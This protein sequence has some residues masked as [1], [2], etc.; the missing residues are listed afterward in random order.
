[1]AFTKEQCEKL[2][3]TFKEGMTDDEVFALVDAKHQESLKVKAS[4]DKASSELATLKKEK[5][6]NLSEEEK[7]KA[8]IA[9]LEEQLAKNQKEATIRDVKDQYVGLGY[10]PELAG[11]I[12]NASIEG[13]H[14]EVAKLQKEFMDAHDAKLKEDFMKSNPKPNQGDPNKGG[15]FTKEN[16]KAGKI[17]Y[18]ELCELQAKNPALYKEITE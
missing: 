5:Q 13:N 10:S 17:T 7:T 3:I 12:A 14:A 11:K 18:D 6:A 8:R 2:G 1:M 9:E 15:K 4:F 16:F